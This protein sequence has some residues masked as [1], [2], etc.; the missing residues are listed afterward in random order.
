MAIDV[1]YDQLIRGQQLDDGDIVTLIVSD[2]SDPN[3]VFVSLVLQG[4]T[5]W[6]GIQSNSTV[7]CQ[8]QDTQINSSAS[9]PASQVQSDG[10][11]LWKAKTFGVHTQMYNIVNP[12]SWANGGKIYTFIWQRD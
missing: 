2:A 5:W 12:R 3:T 10:L 7:L 6:K 1:N 9:L 11:Q 4:V 8:C